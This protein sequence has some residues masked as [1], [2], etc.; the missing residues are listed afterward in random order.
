MRTV[1]IIFVL[2]ALLAIAYYFLVVKKRKEQSGETKPAAEVQSPAFTQSLD[3]AQKTINETTIFVDARKQR[4]KFFIDQLRIGKS[5]EISTINYAS[6]QNILLQNAI[7]KIALTKLD[8]ELNQNVGTNYNL[9]MAH[10]A[11]SGKG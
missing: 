3:A 10:L 6:S 2:L 7:L 1:I 9:L 4:I 11:G 8:R 5:A